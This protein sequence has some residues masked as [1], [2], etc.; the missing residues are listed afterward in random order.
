M[1]GFVIAPT[2]I[3]QP[4]SFF[5]LT[6]LSEKILQPIIPNMWSDVQISLMMAYEVAGGIFCEVISQQEWV[7]N[8][9]NQGLAAYFQFELLSK[10]KHDWNI[11]RYT[12]KCQFFN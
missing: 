2:P 10:V 4:S 7:D 8:W 6:I 11:V 1:L 3:K 9:L 5:G 12:H